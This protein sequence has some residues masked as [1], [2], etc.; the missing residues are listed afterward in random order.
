MHF[1]IFAA[2]TAFSP[3]VLAQSLLGQ[4]PQC[5]VSPSFSDKYSRHS[6]VTF[7]A[8]KLFQQQLRQLRTSGHYLHLWELSYH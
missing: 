8:G 4:L 1:S 2:I 3:T 7:I 6:I 5:T